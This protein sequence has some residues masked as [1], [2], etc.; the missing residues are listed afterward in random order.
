M[1]NRGLIAFLFLLSA[2]AASAADEQN[3]CEV[4]SAMHDLYLVAKAGQAEHTGMENVI[5]RDKGA[6]VVPDAMEQTFQLDDFADPLGEKLAQY[7]IATYV[8]ADTPSRLVQAGADR[9]D[10]A[11]DGKT[12]LV[13]KVKALSERFDLQKLDWTQVSVVTDPTGKKRT[14]IRM[15][16]PEISTRLNPLTPTRQ[17]TF[18]VIGCP[19]PGSSAGQRIQYMAELSVSSYW[20]AR[21]WVGVICAAVYLGVALALTSG[22][23]T[24]GARPGLLRRL[25]PVFITQD[26]LGFGSASRLQVFFFTVVIAATL[27]YIFLRAGYLSEIPSTLLYLLG[28]VGVGGT[29]TKLVAN[30]RV[31]LDDDLTLTTDRW[32]TRHG[33]V[34]PPRTPRWRDLLVT[35]KEFDVYKFQGL[36][37]SGLVGA[38]ILTSGVTSLADITIPANITLLLGLSQAVS[39]G[40]KVVAGPGRKGLNDAVRRAIA[41]ETEL[42]KIIPA[43]DPY[44]YEARKRGLAYSLGQVPSPQQAS[45]PAAARLAY[46]AFKTE[47]AAVLGLASQFLGGG[48]AIEVEPAEPADDT[49]GTF[50]PAGSG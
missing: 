38:W 17:S 1:C 5:L 33:I 12:P 35:G 18:A 26:S 30:A 16:L 32:L 44:H 24:Q 27:A 48:R 28:I 50:A 7:T 37:F 36:V 4:T 40:G 11:D 39:V 47:V 15:Y 3:P 43:A 13:A 19:R 49:A 9:L 41:A 21:V 45:V 10:Q 23:G 29:L 20:Y 25:D 22:R 14:Q 42:L 31:D 34:F 2:S 8:F 6:R 46:A